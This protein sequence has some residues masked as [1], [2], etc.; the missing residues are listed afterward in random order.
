MAT[1]TGENQQRAVYGLLAPLVVIAVMTGLFS[2]ELST[3]LAAV[4]VAVSVVLLVVFPRDLLLGD[5]RALPL[6]AVVLA[7]MVLAAVF[8]QLNGMRHALVFLLLIW[9]VK[10][11]YVRQFHLRYSAGAHK[12]LLRRC[13]LLVFWSHVMVL[14]ALVSPYGELF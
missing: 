12:E 9:L 2:G 4:F 5:Q 13:L 3:Q 10:L 7:G 6:T 8:Y 11:R 1:A 14:V